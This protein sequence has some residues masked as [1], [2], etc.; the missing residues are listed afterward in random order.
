MIIN[1]TNWN[2]KELENHYLHLHK[3]YNNGL[4]NLKFDL[5]ILHLNL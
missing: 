2:S 4:F 1:E 5:I 3:Y